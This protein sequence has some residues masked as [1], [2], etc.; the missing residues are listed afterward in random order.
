MKVL[1]LL[2]NYDSHIIHP[3]LG[4]GY[5]A[6]Y[7]IKNKQ[8]VSIFD[9][10]LKNASLDDYVKV[11]SEFQP[12]LMGI[13]VLTRG[14]NLAKEMVR[15]IKKKF[16]QIP[17]VIGGTQLTAA[18]KEV[19]EDIKP[20][21]GIIGEGEE[22][23]LELVRVLEKKKKIFTKINGLTFF[24][25]NRIIINNLRPLIENL[26]NLPFPAWELMPPK[27]Y[28]IAPILEPAKGFPIAPI[29]TSRGCPYNCSFCASNAT[30][31][32]KLRFRSP[33]NVLEEI[34][35]LKKEYGVEEIHFSDDNFTM[36]I[37][38]AEKICDLLIK[39]KINL[40]WQC[41]N[42]VRIDR[43][44]TSLLKKM[45][46]AGCYSLSLGI[47]SGNQE[48]LKN[49]QKQLDL[50]IVPGVLK[51]L[52]NIG[53]ESYGFFILGLPGETKGSAK[54][55]IDFALN[56]DFDRVWFNIFTPYPG[57]SAFADW[58]G[59]RH[60]SDINWNEHDCST[61]LV[62][63]KELSLSQIEKMQKMALRKFYLRPKNFA[64]VISH[65]G[66]KE[67]TSFLM[68]RFF[69]NIFKLTISKKIKNNV[70]HNRNF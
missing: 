67:I 8:I 3:P 31:R 56:N 40:P 13:S 50:K 21:F 36:D 65:I 12:D 30:W 51:M 38:R 15:T 58:I 25:N 16:S 20:D 19:M 28:R 2:P 70:W 4:L 24:S 26:D 45:K 69:K 29:L 7:L 1:F 6:S 41:P 55:T 34:K 62:S 5:L 48:M 49:V 37:E 63:S 42:G 54:E 43:L 59:N 68:S 11:I 46:K 57:S 23:I 60:F 35:M 53:I 66:P 33:E 44:T 10:T 39:E 9:G 14:H 61:A 17:I 22:T 18:P 47:E 27:E 32:R 52:R 64:R